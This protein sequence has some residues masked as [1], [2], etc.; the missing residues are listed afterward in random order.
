M[1]IHVASR[2]TVAAR[3]APMPAADQAL[4]A[5]RWRKITIVIFE[6]VAL[7]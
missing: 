3:V 1:I 6:F 7:N 4:M 2:D 5:V